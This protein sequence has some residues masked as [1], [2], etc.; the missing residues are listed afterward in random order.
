[1]DVRAVLQVF[2]RL[3]SWPRL[4]FAAAVSALVSVLAYLALASVLPGVSL[5]LASFA[6]FLAF[7]GF[8]LSVWPVERKI[9]LSRQAEV[10]GY[11]LALVLVVYFAVGGLL[12]WSLNAMT[13]ENLRVPIAWDAPMVRPWEATFLRRVTF[14]PFYA[15]VLVGCQSPLPVPPGAC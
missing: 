4:G 12:L 3:S 2:V 5:L 1:M 10:V 6:M 14:W 8:A 11:R 13:P 9:T 15:L 7:L